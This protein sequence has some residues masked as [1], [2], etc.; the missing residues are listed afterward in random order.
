M[1]GKRQPGGQ[2]EPPQFSLI[3]FRQF[4]VH[5]TS[6]QGRLFHFSSRQNRLSMRVSGMEI[7]KKFDTHQGSDPWLI[8]TIGAL[9]ADMGFPRP[10]FH[11]GGD[12]A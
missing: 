3:R 6:G 12:N 2:S 4:S 8:P 11:E 1:A 5:E 9:M 10:L 7:S